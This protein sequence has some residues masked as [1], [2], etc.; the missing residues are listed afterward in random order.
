M[1]VIV[2]QQSAIGQKT[3]VG[4]YTYELLRHLRQRADG[5]RIDGFPCGWERHVVKAWGRV[6]PAFEPKVSEHA[7]EGGRATALARGRK[8]AV[9]AVRRGGRAFMAARLRRLCRTQQYQLYHETNFV[10]YDVDCPTVTTIHD[11]SA[12]LH[13]DWHPA[14]RVRHF[15]RLFRQSLP[16]SRHFVTVSRFTRDEVVRHLGIPADRVSV[17]YN[18]IRPE[19]GPRGAAEVGADAPRAGPAAALLPVPGDAGAAE[20]PAAAAGGVLRPAGAGAGGVPAGARRPVG[21]EGGPDRP[22]PARCGPAPRRG[23]RGLRPGRGPGGGV[24]R[25][26]A[27][28]YPSHYEGFGLPP[29]E[30]MA[31]GGAVLTSTAGALAEMFG[32]QARPGGPA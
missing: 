29:V 15:E 27:L 12:L 19:L 31:C 9:A 14:E 5:G 11:L 24:Q 3:G 20:E 32:G 26:R 25:A 17:T 21:L 1:R 23:P 22:V 8:R 30:M 13:P 10:P 2:N 4:C 18:G 28:V 6:R 16:R 7:V